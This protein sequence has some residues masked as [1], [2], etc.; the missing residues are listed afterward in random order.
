A[1]GSATLGAAIVRQGPRSNAG[2]AECKIR[3]NSDGAPGRFHE[4]GG[5]L[6]LGS[7]TC[8]PRAAWRHLGISLASPSLRTGRYYL[9]S[10]AGGGGPAG[11]FSYRCDRHDA[12]HVGNG[13]EERKL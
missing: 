8:W 2:D 10:P 13:R 12:S 3:W 1:A 5:G 11:I 7:V 4:D 6:L 9:P